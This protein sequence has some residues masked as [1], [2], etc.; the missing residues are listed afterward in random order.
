[1]TQ[2]MR[3]QVS[4]QAAIRMQLNRPVIVKKEIKPEI[5]PED[6]PADQ[7][8]W[9]NSQLKNETPVAEP[10]T[11]ESLKRQ[12][13]T[14]K[15]EF[16]RQYIENARKDGYHVILSPELKVLSVTPIRQPSQIP[17]STDSFP[18]E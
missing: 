5:R 15:K 13:E 18:A 16:A 17:D 4:S 9:K 3:D 7:Q 1:A 6:I 8:I 11:L 12:E 14:E 10:Q 2:I